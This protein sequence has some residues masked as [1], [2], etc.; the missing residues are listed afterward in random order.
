MKK[1]IYGDRTVIE[2]TVEEASSCNVLWE[3]KMKDFFRSR[4]KKVVYVA[5]FML[6]D[7]IALAQKLSG[8]AR[9]T[10]YTKIL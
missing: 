5:S 8:R 4:A 6:T 10:K 7:N 9:T 2:M 1:Y 3:Q